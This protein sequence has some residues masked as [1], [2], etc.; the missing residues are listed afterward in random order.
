MKSSILRTCTLGAVLALFTAACGDNPSAFESRMPSDIPV[1]FLENDLFNGV[2]DNGCMGN[3][4]HNSGITSGLNS[5]TGLNCTANDI[6]LASAT[7]VAF[8][9]ENDVKQPIQAGQNITCTEGEQVDVEVVALLG[10]NAN[11]ARTDI[12]VWISQNFGT[13]EAQAQAEVGRCAHY[14][15]KPGADGASQLDGDKCGDMIAGGEASINLGRLTIACLPNQNDQVELG[16]CIG[17]TQPGGDIQCP[18]GNVESHQAYRFGTVPANKSKC[19]CEPFALNITVNK[20]AHLEVAKACTPANDTGKFNLQI[21]GTNY[22]AGA[23]NVGDVACGGST[24]KIELGAGTNVSPGA[25]H[26]FQEL[27]GTGTSLDNYTT[28]WECRNRGAVTGGGRGSGTNLTANNITLQPDDDVVCTFTNVRKSNIVIRKATDPTGDA[29]VFQFAA[30]GGLAPAAFQ[31]SHG[32]SQAF[33]NIAPN[34][35]RFTETVPA[36]WDLTSISCTFA[37]GAS[38]VDNLASG[39]TDITVPAGGSADCTFNNRKRANVI[40]RKVTNPAASPGTFAFTAAGGSISPANFSLDHGQSQNFNNIIPNVAYTFTETTLPAFYSLQSISCVGS[41][42]Q[43]VPSVPSKNVII[44]PIAGQTVDCTF[45]NLYDPPEDTHGCSP[46]FW[47]NKNGVSYYGLLPFDP[48]TYQVKQLFS[49]A[50]PVWPSVGNATLFEA[51]NGYKDVSGRP[52]RNSVAGAAEILLRHAIAAY[53]NEYLFPATFPA[54][55]TAAIVTAVNAAINSGDRDVILKLNDVFSA[56]VN[57]YI[58][59]YE[60]GHEGDLL[61]AYN[62]GEEDPGFAGCYFDGKNQLQ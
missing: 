48:Y 27:A 12:G 5:P 51:L 18:I 28:S 23:A 35:Y 1:S 24:G 36:G 19:N 4:A 44:T 31:L 15:L 49:A 46:G 38:K 11:S 39:Y 42:A 53:F 56:M 25:V 37:G 55:S 16:S 59:A 26:T 21:D 33:N 3:D 62:T 57:G 54:P 32:G 9:D 61:Y 8:W 40:I 14:N 2:Y 58:V 29:Q 43:A 13:Q 6:Y 22:N 60:L 45:T 47:T 41:P 30:G 10:Q 7:A 20:K 52:A 17:W 50:G 34:T